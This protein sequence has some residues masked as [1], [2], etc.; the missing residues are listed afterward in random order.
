MFNQPNSLAFDQGGVQL[1]LDQLVKQFKRSHVIALFH[2]EKDQQSLV[3][4]EA[5][6]AV[7]ELILKFVNGLFDGILRAP[8]L[9]E[10]VD[11]RNYCGGLHVNG[12]VNQSLS[13]KLFDVL[14]ILLIDDFGQDSE[15]VGLE[16]IILSSLNIFLETGYDYEDFIFTNVQFFDEN[17]NKSPQVLVKLIPLR[18]RDLEKFGHIEKQSAFII[19]IK[20]LAL[21]QKENYL[22]QEIN[23]LFFLECLLVEHLGALH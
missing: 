9:L 23:T 19:P 3:L 16:H 17:V 21:I 5:I 11:V 22:V 2:F 7:V 6:C 14:N 15:C 4:D 18:L 10:Q 1:L 13:Q 20:T 12:L 8:F